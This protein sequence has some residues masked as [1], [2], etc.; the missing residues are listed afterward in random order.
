MTELLLNR[1]DVVAEVQGCFLAYDRALLDND[2]PALDGWFLDD[3][4]TL[5]FGVAEELYGS[6]A[7]AAHRRDSAGVRRA[8]FR[9]Y[10][11]VTVETDFAVVTAEFDEPDGSTGR[12]SQT[13]IR[14]PAGWRVL[15]AHVSI[16]A[17]S[18]PQ[19]STHHRST[20]QASTQERMSS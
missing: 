12:Q 8:P 5:R 15:S 17:S 14:T 18:A 7:I 19:A 20:S 16:R 6:S 1:P 4:R 3:P 2:V 11:V 9:R 10:D 13:W